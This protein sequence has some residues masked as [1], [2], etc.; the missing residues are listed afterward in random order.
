MAQKLEA[1]G[2]GRVSL[3]LFNKLAVSPKSSGSQGRL[4]HEIM[5]NYEIAAPAPPGGPIVLICVFRSNLGTD[6]G[7]TWALIPAA[8]GR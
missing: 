7:A 1:L 8:P 6:S 2:L 3:Q 5:D 4:W